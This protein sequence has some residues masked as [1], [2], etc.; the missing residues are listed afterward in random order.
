MTRVVQ[1]GSEPL[2]DYVLPPDELAAQV[3]A[4]KEVL[5]PLGVAVTVSEMA[6]GYQAH[7]GASSVLD[8]VDIIDAHMLPFFAQDAGTASA[9]W[10]LVLRDLDWFFANGGGKK[11]Y[12][13]EN[14]WPSQ[15]SEGVQPNSPDAVADVENEEAYYTLLDAR[16]PYFKAVSIGWFAHIYGE[17]MEPGCVFFLFG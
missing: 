10:P 1:F 14:G 12:L 8:A 7:G 5:N 15:T 2:Y 17:Y 9:S 3:R 11:M 6:Y 13:S 16:C 4:A